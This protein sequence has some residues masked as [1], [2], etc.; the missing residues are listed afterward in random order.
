MV[1]A[2]I[3]TLFYIFVTN[4]KSP[5]FLSSSFAYIAPMS[6]LYYDVIQKLQ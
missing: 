1:S 4:G 3:G 6:S 2:V 5:V